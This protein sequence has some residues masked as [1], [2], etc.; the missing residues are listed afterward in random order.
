MQLPLVM[1][2]PHWLFHQ[3]TQWAFLNSAWGFAVT[4]LHPGLSQHLICIL[5]CPGGILGGERA[6]A[7]HFNILQL[8]MYIYLIK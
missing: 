3:D 7:G 1:A 4:S 5:I 6:R 8:H 2:S